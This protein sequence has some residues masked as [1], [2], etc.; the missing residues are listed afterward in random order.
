MLSDV[1]VISKTG[2]HDITSLYKIFS[3]SVFVS[4]AV[5]TSVFSYA[6]L[7][8]KVMS[9]EQYTDQ[10]EQSFKRIPDTPP[11]N[12]STKYDIMKKHLFHE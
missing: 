3:L 6:Q 12:N 4:I 10:L 2:I 8:D 5:A 1:S 9:R 11:E 7:T